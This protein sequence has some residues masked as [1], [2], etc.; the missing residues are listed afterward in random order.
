[1]KLRADLASEPDGL[2]VFG[3]G[4]FEAATGAGA[5]EID[6]EMELKKEYRDD[7]SCGPR[8]NRRGF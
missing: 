4:V 1:V 5:F 7:T 8:R 2:E 3:T 6:P